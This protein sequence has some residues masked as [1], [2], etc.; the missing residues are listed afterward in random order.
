MVDVP[1]TCYDC[2]LTKEE[3]EDDIFCPYKEIYIN[4]YSLDGRYHECPIIKIPNKI[5][6]ISYPPV[7]TSELDYAAGWNDC[8]DA[9]MGGSK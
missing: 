5:T 6:D 9:I 8:I 1:K 7:D 4:H 3:N 2:R